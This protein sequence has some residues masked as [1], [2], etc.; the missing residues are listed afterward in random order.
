MAPTGNTAKPEDVPAKS[1]PDTGIETP[2][3]SS[4]ASIKVKPV[5]PTSKFRVESVPEI[6][7]DGTMLTAAQLKLAEDAAKASGVSLVV[8]KEGGSK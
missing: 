6:T 1:T 8:D 3:E 2:D 4:R 5:W 7:A